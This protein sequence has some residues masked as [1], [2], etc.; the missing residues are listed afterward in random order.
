MGVLIMIEDKHVAASLIEKR[1]Q[2]A[3]EIK[4]LELQID[5]KRNSLLHID[6]TIEIL[7]P[8]AVID[9]AD[10]P[11]RRTPR[12]MGYFARGELR[13]RCLT[14]LREAGGEPVKIAD[15]TLR[16]MRDKRLDPEN[17][18]LR[19]QFYHRFMMAMHDMARQ[20]GIVVRVGERLNVSWKLAE[21]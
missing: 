16:A 5:E 20:Q 12:R 11:E 13:K 2:I 17:R 10:A 19:K 18:T 8:E 1:K 9:T 4:D 15:I 6:N 14:A 3:R 21:D 7:D